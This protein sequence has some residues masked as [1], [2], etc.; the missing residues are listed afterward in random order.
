MRFL[1]ADDSPT[2]RRIVVNSLKR[3]GFT[4]TVEAAD[5]VEALE[6]FDSTV[7]FVI[8]DWNMP[9]LGGLGLV[10]ALRSKPEGKRIP[11]V[12][13]T[14]RLVE[15]DYARAAQDT[16]F[17]CIVKPFTPRVLR[18]KVERLAGLRRGAA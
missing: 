12:M 6:R 8:T 10:R 3:I 15:A 4:D 5:G 16:P 11:I 13:I 9:Q 18:E 7:D 17:E 14:T 1:V 2:M